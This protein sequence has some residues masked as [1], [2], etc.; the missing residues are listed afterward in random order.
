MPTRA[1]KYNGVRQVPA[2]TILGNN[3]GSVA[4]AI[5]LTPDQISAMGVGGFSA[6]AQTQITPTTAIVLDEATGNE[7]AL[8]LSHTVNKATSGNNTG[9]LMDI[10][11]TASPGT[12]L[13]IDLQVDAS[14]RFNIDT[15][16]NVTLNGTVDGR[17]IATDGTKLDGIEALA[18]VTDTANVTAAVALMDSEVDADLKTLVLPR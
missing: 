3:T 2:N 11:D 16:G 8:D 12:S 5:A 15:L 6:D 4:A 14:S 7:T 18:D 9:I 10:T 13:F 17:D 1:V